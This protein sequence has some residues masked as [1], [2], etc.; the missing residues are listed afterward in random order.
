MERAEVADE[1]HNSY[2]VSAKSLAATPLGC[3]S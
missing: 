2:L 3:V 1:D